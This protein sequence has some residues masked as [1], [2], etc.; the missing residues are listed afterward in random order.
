[1][2]ADEVAEQKL[3]AS[4]ETEPFAAPVFQSTEDT[5]SASFIDP[6]DLESIPH[7]TLAPQWRRKQEL[8]LGGAEPGEAPRAT[9]AEAARTA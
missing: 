5:P 2:P 4:A 3:A 8:A 7:A 1:V 9:A 6:T